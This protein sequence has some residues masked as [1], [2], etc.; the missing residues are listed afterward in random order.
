[1]SDNSRAIVPVGQRGVVASV[2]R[3]IAITEKLLGRIQSVQNLLD[4]FNVPQ[5]GSFEEAIIRIRPGGL[6][7]IAAGRY[8]LDAGVTINKPLRIMGADRDLTIIASSARG[9][10][11]AVVTDG[12]FVMENVGILRT[13]EHPGGLVSISAREVLLKSCAFTGNRVEG[14]KEDWWGGLRF[15][16]CA[17]G[18]V[19]DSSVTCCLYGIIV[20]RSADIQLQRN[21]CKNNLQVG[22]LLKEQS[23]VQLIA[24]KCEENGSCGIRFF[25]AAGKAEKNICRTN[26]LGGIQVANSKTILSGNCCEENG[27]CGISLRESSCKVE[28]NICRFNVMSGILVGYRSKVVLFG[29]QCIENRR[30]GIFVTGSVVVKVKNNIC[31]LNITKGIQVERSK[32]KLIGNLCEENGNCGISFS[33]FAIGNAEHNICN[34]N[35]RVGIRVLKNSEANLIGNHCEENETNGILYSKSATGTAENN[36]CR[37]NKRKGLLVLDSSSVVL[38]NNICEENGD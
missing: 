37:L 11:L 8:I 22:I 15:A 27:Y 13:G 3:Q 24:N 30:Y 20:E 35:K 16:D 2:R 28:N 6:I 12:L 4:V 34:L 26:H 17:V 5:D 19:E 36:I 23:K 7:T 14:K 18:V 38:L 1:M 31:K 21:S 25:G 10:I 29:N 33:E 32:A 9:T